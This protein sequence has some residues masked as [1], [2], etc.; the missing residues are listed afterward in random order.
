MGK[1]ERR[2]CTRTNRQCAFQFEKIGADGSKQLPADGMLV[3][4][5]IA[6]IRFT[7]KEQLEK[8]TPLLI[9]FDLDVFENDAEDWRHLWE[10]GDATSLKVVGSVM[11][12]LASKNEPGEF[13][14]GTRFVAI[15]REKAVCSSLFQ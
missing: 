8:N 14:V 4:Y 9:Q 3:D 11:W 5:S 6:G 10:A 2:E 7:T 12:C 13:E 15:N 1:N